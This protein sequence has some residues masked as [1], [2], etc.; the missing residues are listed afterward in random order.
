MDRLAAGGAAVAG[1]LAGS[2]V[3][4][5]SRASL[6]TGRLPHQHGVVAN[7]LPLSPE[8]DTLATAL[9]AAG[10]RTGWIGKWHLAGLPRDKWVPPAARPGIGY[11]A[12]VD[13]SHQHVDGHYYIGQEAATGSPSPATS[14]GPRPASPWTSS[15]KQTAAPSSSRSPTTRPTTRT[16]RCPPTCGP[17]T[18]PNG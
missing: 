3:C 13:C 11:Y 16:T 8:L 12:G 14:R 6:L 9:S 10:Y 5:P 2:P 17:A 15:P 18:R 4:G 7:D 1:G